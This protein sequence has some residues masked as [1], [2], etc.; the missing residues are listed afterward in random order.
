[1]GAVKRIFYKE[2]RKQRINKKRFE[3]FRRAELIG[4]MLVY[5]SW[6]GV[7][8]TKG[9]MQT[10]KGALRKQRASRQAH[11]RFGQSYR[12]RER[13]NFNVKA[14][15]IPSREK[16]FVQSVMVSNEEVQKTY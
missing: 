12:M 9:E 11:V 16:G 15:Q 3:S 8:L 5:A 7:N 13:L 6:P 2:N 1:M 14:K 10:I 4:H